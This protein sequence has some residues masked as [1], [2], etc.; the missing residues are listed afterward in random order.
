MPIP[1]IGLM[2]LVSNL[3]ILG[4]KEYT[5]LS[6]AFLFV[7]P[8]MLEKNVIYL[9]IFFLSAFALVENNKQNNAY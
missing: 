4:I 7:F 9:N 8:Y 5:L 6:G 1:E 2:S 3:R